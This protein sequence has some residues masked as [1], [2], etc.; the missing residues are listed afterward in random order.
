MVGSGTPEDPEVVDAE[1]PRDRLNKLRE[2]RERRR[3]QMQ[4]AYLAADEDVNR[5]EEELAEAKRLRTELAGEMTRAGVPLPKRPTRTTVREVREETTRTTA[6]AD[7]VRD[8]LRNA[9]D[10][11]KK[12]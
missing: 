1:S 11:L 5:L 4:E 10:W 12:H 9:W 7:D 8:S 3:I 2:A 6:A